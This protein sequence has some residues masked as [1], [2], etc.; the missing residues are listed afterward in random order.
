[1]LSGRVLPAHPHPLSNEL[2][3]SW[4]TRTAQ[5]NGI[6]VH[7]LALHLWN[8]D[9]AIAAWARDIDR[10]MSLSNL[11]L[12]S[13]RTGIPFCE[14]K[15][16]TLGS[17]EGKLA[18]NIYKNTGDPFVLPC[19]TKHRLKTRN[20]LVY[21][22]TC[23]REDEVPY[24]RLNWRISLSTI[25]PKHGTGMFD[26]CPECGSPINFVRGE[27]GQR[28][29]TMIHSICRC[30]SCGFDLRSMKTKPRWYPDSQTLS[31]HISLLNQMGKDSLSFQNRE[32]I[33]GL[34][35]YPV[36]VFLARFLRNRRGREIA[37]LLELDGY[38]A[39]LSYTEGKRTLSEMSIRDRHRFLVAAIWLLSEWPDR[40]IHYFLRSSLPPSFL[41]ENNSAPFWFVHP[42]NNAFYAPGP[43]RDLM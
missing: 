15:R 18:Q 4:L 1:V 41:N 13:Q 28:F 2:F 7:S 11:F 25:C 43:Q 5:A 20:W 21:C 14:I 37:K 30:S 8:R 10:S 12:A 33:R 39:D 35:F 3:S 38:F 32:F 23:L 19:G 16:T 31:A 17:F 26:Q 9:T 34:Q 36:V 6:K 42:I 29:V 22:P 24:Y 40:F 27:L